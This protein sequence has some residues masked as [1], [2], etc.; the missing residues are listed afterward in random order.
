MSVQVRLATA[1][2]APAL[3]KFRYDFRTRNMSGQEQEA[4][5]LERCAVWMRERLGACGAWRCWIAERE[6]AAVGHVW[7]QLFEKI[8]NPTSESEFHA[9][10]TNFYVLE[11]ARGQG[12][13]SGLLAA[14]LDW[15]R[16]SHV[17]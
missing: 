7:I 16:A 9:Y 11:E 17:H 14:A 15:C 3:A 6:G 4:A 12:V 2:D 5:F 13:G 1:A 8:P 10:L